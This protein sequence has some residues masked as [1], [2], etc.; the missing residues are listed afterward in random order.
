[1]RLLRLMPAISA[2]SLIRQDLLLVRKACLGFLVLR[3]VVKVVSDEDPDAR[4]GIV[5]SFQP[6]SAGVSRIVVT[7]GLDQVEQL[8][9]R[10]EY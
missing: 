9:L 5:D 3:E 1:M 10:F 2:P 7:C 4:L 8:F 6:A